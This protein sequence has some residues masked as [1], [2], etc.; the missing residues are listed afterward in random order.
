VVVESKLTTN[1]Q[2][3][4][5]FETQ[6]KEYQKAEKTTEG[7]YLIIDVVGGSVKRLNDLYSLVTKF[8]QDGLRMPEIYYID[9]KPKASASVYN[10]NDAS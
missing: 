3:L 10:S 2:L 9:A 5:G 6:I 8:K 7:I 4:H 1:N